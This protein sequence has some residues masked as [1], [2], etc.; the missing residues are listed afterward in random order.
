MKENKNI[1]RLF[2][3]KF[4]DFE[5][6]PP[7]DAWAAIEKRLNEKKKKRRV[8]PIWFKASGIAAS[9]VLGFFLFNTI[10]N[11]L[12][13]N[14]EVNPKN[15]EEKA[16]NWVNQNSNQENGNSN[17]EQKSKN[18][19]GVFVQPGQ[20]VTN[21]DAVSNENLEN[22]IQIENEANSV[23]RTE[24]NLQGTKRNQS[25]RN[26]LKKNNS[27][28]T[29]V[30]TD[31]KK[32]SVKNPNWIKIETQE[33]IA[34]GNS[35]NTQNKKKKASIASQ[36]KT[37]EQLSQSTNTPLANQETEK[38]KIAIEKEKQILNQTNSQLSNGVATSEKTENKLVTQQAALVSEGVVD[39]N[40]TNAVDSVL[41]SKKEF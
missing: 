5:V 16:P 35:S 9:L 18:K 36:T 32:S 34:D 33:S 21:V 27:K 1:E 37:T 8:I 29:W 14:V 2:Q 12:W 22:N 25:V 38:G 11:S 17:F 10:Q 6:Q 40:K 39:L 28:E 13:P 3:E 30:Q 24:T 31:K 4:K 23:S 41:V 15:N 26:P 7:Q 20:V 19:N